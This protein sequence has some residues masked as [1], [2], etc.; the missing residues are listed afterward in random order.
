MDSSESLDFLQQLDEASCQ[1]WEQ[2]K[3]EQERAA[4]PLMEEFLKH[5]LL[6]AQTG[7]TECR[8][9]I[10]TF[11]FHNVGQFSN[12]WNKKPDCQQGF[13]TFL[14]QKLQAVVGQ[15]SQASVSLTGVYREDVN[16]VMPQGFGSTGIVLAATWPEPTLRAVQHSR[17]HVPRSNLISQCPVCLC[18]AEVVA[19]TPCGHV[20]CVSCST[21]FHRGTTCPVCREPVAGRQNLFS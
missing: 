9:V 2:Q 8:N 15:N 18:Q 3:A 16:G 17:E 6:A 21:G 11:F 1:V 13:A 14:Q 20:V 12:D 5:C 19:L 10:G 4:R 7:E